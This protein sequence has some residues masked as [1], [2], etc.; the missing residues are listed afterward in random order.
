MAES[1]VLVNQRIGRYL[2]KGFINQGGMA[3]VYLAHDEDL[4]RD[5]CLKVMLAGL[6]QHPD[7][8]R[9]FHREAQTIARLEH[10]NILQIYDI[11]LTPQ[12]RPYLAMEYIAGGSLYD[13]LVAHE[14]RG[15]H[16][17]P[18]RALELI[19]SVSQALTVV[20]QAGV[21]HRDLKPSNILLRS[22]GTPILAD[23]GI[24][25]VQEATR[26]TRT[27]QMPGTAHYMSPEQVKG[28]S[29]DGR[30]DI[31]SLGIILYELLSG[32][33]PFNDT[34][35]M[36][37]L[38]RQLHEKPAPLARLCP[39]LSPAT[40]RLVNTCL[41]KNPTRRYQSTTELVA[42]LERAIAAEKT[43]RWRSPLLARLAPLL[44]RPQWW[45]YP[46]VPI[47][48]IALL[49]L[50]RGV[51]SSTP[52]TELRATRIPTQA[53]AVV[54][55]QLSP[56]AAAVTMPLINTP[57]PTD[58]PS[59]APT[60]SP[61]PEATL[62]PE[63]TL[64]LLPTPTPV[65]PLIVVTATATPAA[66]LAEPGPRWGSTLYDQFKERLGCA[67]NPE[68]R[69]VGAYQ[70]FQKGLMVWRGDR[71][72]VYVLYYDSGAYTVHDV[73]NVPTT[74]ENNSDMLKGAFGWLW[75]AQE[76][77]RDRLSTPTM[78][79]ANTTD[80]AIQDFS[81]GVIYYFLEN[82]ANNYVLFNDQNTWLTV[83]E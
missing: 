44:A 41:Q 80:F 25:A 20:H 46:I 3:E 58:T 23:M 1:E 24:V 54:A 82:N 34:D 14:H 13:E 15:A 27:G 48:L 12:Q 67:L 45:V 52:A 75:N 71:D 66:C 10:P 26:L 5:V 47:F 11:G 18:V 35:R 30:S 38:Q 28:L 32:Q 39:G 59:P 33:L 49:L 4:R 57:L 51:F 42:A 8:I 77:I 6:A 83:R 22:D 79:E 81:G 29:L 65:V 64:T 16:L 78:A 74:Y 63:P 56:T 70:I 37:I 2:V 17:T 76:S 21:V 73:H 43:S 40:Y 19:R 53:P 62:T 69:P 72:L 31:Y 61:T 55:R 68:N 60:A 7:L 50:G 9:R 36:L